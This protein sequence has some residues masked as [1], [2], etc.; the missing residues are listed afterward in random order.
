MRSADKCGVDPD[1]FWLVQESRRRALALRFDQLDKLAIPAGPNP[2]NRELVCSVGG[3]F[4]RWTRPP[5]LE[6]RLLAADVDPVSLDLGLLNEEAIAS[7]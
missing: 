4:Q 3:S 1:L 7:S 2:D 5:Q 6:A